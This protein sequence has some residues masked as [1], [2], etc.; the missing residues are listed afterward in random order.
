[1]GSD[2]Q[3]LR[4]PR[5]LI[6]IGYLILTIG[7]AVTVWGERSGEPYPKGFRVYDLATVISFALLGWAWWSY[8]NAVESI[9]TP[10][11]RRSL[12]MFAAVSGL[13]A[14]GNVALMRDL[15][16]NLVHY[17]GYEALLKELYH[18]PDGRPLY[19]GMVVS[20]I[21]FCV[22]AVGFWWASR[23][24]TTQPES[25]DMASGYEVAE[26]PAP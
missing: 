5:L 22:V 23:A 1:M 7:T 19:K 21:G 15:F 12:R 14:V 3:P 20:V 10:Q 2:A 16:A 11:V 24:S 17:S 13:L 18:L 9:S 25:S 8:L 6:L 4:R 26:V